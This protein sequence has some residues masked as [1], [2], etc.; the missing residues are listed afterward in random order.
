MNDNNSDERKCLGIKN[1][2]KSIKES[3]NTKDKFI[4]I[5]KLTKNINGL[6]ENDKLTVLKSIDP[7]FLCLL[8]RSKNEFKLF[9]LRLINSLVSTS[10]YIF[11]KKCIPYVNSI[12]YYYLTHIKNVNNKLR[13]FEKE[14]DEQDEVYDVFEDAD[15]TK[16]INPLYNESLTFFLKIEPLLKNEN[17]IKTTYINYEDND[18]D[19][20]VEM[21]FF[22]KKLKKK[23]HE[24]N[25]T[26]NLNDQQI[27]S[28]SEIEEQSDSSNSEDNDQK[29]NSKENDFSFQNEKVCLVELFF[30]VLR[31]NIAIHVEKKEEGIKR[32]VTEEEVKNPEV[33][34]GKSVIKK[35][36]ENLD[37][38]NVLLTKD[39]INV[40]LLF[41]NNIILK[42]N[43]TKFVK[44]YFNL[45]NK[46]IE[47]YRVEDTINTAINCLTNLNIYIKNKNFQNVLN[48]NEI[49]KF[50]ANVIYL[51]SKIKN[52]KEKKNLYKLYSTIY[53]CLNYVYENKN[54][55]DIFKTPLSYMNVELYIFFEDVIKY[56]NNEKK[57]NYIFLNNQFDGMI[58]LICNNIY[59][60][61]NFLNQCYS[62]SD[63]YSLRESMDKC[64]TEEGRDKKGCEK[65]AEGGIENVE[66][67]KMEANDIYIIMTKIKRSIELLVEF[68]K[69]IKNVFKGYDENCENFIDFKKKFSKEINPLICLFCNYLIHENVHYIDDFLN[70]LELFTIC[71]ED[72]NF[73][74]LIMVIKHIDTDKYFSNKKFLTTTFLY[75]F[76]INMKNI[77]HINILFNLFNKCT[78]NIIDFIQ[79]SK[80]DCNINCINNIYD[81]F[82]QNPNKEYDLIQISHIPIDKLN[83]LSFV[84]LISQDEYNKQNIKNIINFSNNFFIYYYFNVLHKNDDQISPDNFDIYK[85][86]YFNINNNY[87]QKDEKTFFLSIKIL[88]TISSILFIRFNSLV[89]S[90]ILAKHEV[91]FIQDCL[92]MSLFNLKAS[93]GDTKNIQEIRIN[94][95]REKYFLKTLKVVYFLL[96]YNPYFVS[97]FIFRLKQ[98]KQINDNISFEITNTKMTKEYHISICAVLNRLIEN[99][100]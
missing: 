32:E 17:F 54:S 1:I 84:Y 9:T 35:N 18:I 22:K 93:K 20:D 21:Y 53:P 7:E 11:L 47:N 5:L 76:N 86:N 80:E 81:K 92:I 45:L 98:A 33:E 57:Q 23:Y 2:L 44:E 99:Y 28:G 30:D 97:L 19:V 72:Q 66:L 50:Y 88:L 4:N 43:Y 74:Y 100:V 6:N 46:I 40:S 71:L 60:V 69:D 62:V 39:N 26:Q 78:Y 95:K 55:S 77:I 24:E 34:H 29:N 64:S 16:D 79:I 49:Y 12:I 82:K 13:G 89:V 59:N 56:L 51:F 85:N 96:Y 25:D 58:Q 90:T 63:K 27:N 87:I 68:F 83:N 3:E 65:K 91:F 52:I 75:I 73:F 94:K 38:E 61:V 48:K 42:V 8:L 15:D 67:C 14:V 36:V 70:L 10:T 37:L 31:E 41:L